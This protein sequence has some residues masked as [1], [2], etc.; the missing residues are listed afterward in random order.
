MSN[1]RI[2][3]LPPDAWTDE[4][5]AILT[6]A[7]GAGSPL[8][9]AQLGELR[10]FTTLA[11]HDATFKSLLLL[12][13]RLVMRA[14]LP[15]ADRELLILRTAWNCRSAYEWGQHARIAVDG[16]V[17]RALVDRVP[18]GP[19]DPGW[20]RHR[21]LLLRAADELH[22]DA[23]ITDATWGGLAVTLDE[24]Q[25]IE[26]PQ[27]VGYYHLVAYVLGALRIASEPGSEPL[28]AAP[29]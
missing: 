14:A 10:L 11:R 26:L 9:S 28:P 27:L 16:G 17:D 18:A 20:D 8:G 6:A 4:Q 25:L 7:V 24:P 5:R 15:F 19:D 2:D 13:R 3:P 21:A 22:V 1:P 12:G 23:A 29:G